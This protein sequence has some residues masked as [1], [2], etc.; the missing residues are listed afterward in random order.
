MINNCFPLL[1]LFLGA[2]QTMKS[3][4]ASLPLNNPSE[5][6]KIDVLVADQFGTDYGTKEN[7]KKDYTIV[8]Q[9]DKKLEDLISNVHFFIYDKK[10]ESIVFEDKLEAGTVDWHSDY[11]IV[12]IS[13]VKNANDGTRTIREYYY[14]VQKREKRAV[15]D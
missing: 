5:R 11:E 1:I 8:F 13:R 10:T 2:C 9:Q 3:D 14:D 7:K 6:S 4:S 12:A 15:E